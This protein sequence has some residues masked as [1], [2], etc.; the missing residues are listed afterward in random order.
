MDAFGVHPERRF[1][2]WDWVG[3]RYSVWSSVGLALAVAIGAKHFSEFLEGA[4]GL[5]QHARSAPLEKNLP[6]LVA[7]VGVW[8]INFQQLPTL[9][10]L[11]YTDRLARL[12]AYLQQLDME[13]NGKSVSIGGMPISWGTAP[14]LWGEPGNNAQHSFFQMLHQGTLRAALEFIVVRESPAGAQH[15]QQLATANALAQIE[16][17]TV[18]QGGDD[19]HRRHFGNRPLAVIVLDSLTPRSLGALLAL[20]EHKVYVQSLLWGINAFDQFGVEL[21]KKIFGLSGLTTAK[22]WELLRG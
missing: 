10:V 4:H 17:F 18:G 19:T 21:G 12:P 14:V 3:G 2:M 13:S 8:N 11:P 9:A 20:Y 15:Q 6:A 1:A 16:S 5:D 7:A 22:L